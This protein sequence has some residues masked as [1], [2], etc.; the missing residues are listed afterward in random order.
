M[1]REWSKSQR[2]AYATTTG[3]TLLEE[4]RL[5]RARGMNQG[6]PARDSEGR[7]VGAGEGDS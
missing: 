3:G 7:G 5:E 6:A 4:G 1:R 2:M